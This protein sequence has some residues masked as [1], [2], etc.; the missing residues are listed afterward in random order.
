MDPTEFAAHKGKQKAEEGDEYKLSMPERN[1]FCSKREWRYHSSALQGKACPSIALW[2]LEQV[3]QQL[4]LPSL[5]QA[6]SSNENYSSFEKAMRRETRLENSRFPFTGTWCHL[7][8]GDFGTA[9]GFWLGLDDDDHI[10]KLPMMTIFKADR[11]SVESP[12]I[13]RPYDRC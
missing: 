6:E 12:N 5:D 9:E 8:T 10:Q 3:L 4:Q 11:Y 7:G 13:T 2:Q 1:P